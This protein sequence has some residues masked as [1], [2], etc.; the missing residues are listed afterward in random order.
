M[1]AHC[2]QLD[3]LRGFAILLVVLSHCS[4][5]KQG[6]VANAIFFALS[7]F[8]FVNPFKDGYEQRFLSAKNILKFYRGRAL[9]ILPS[10]YLVLLLI[11]LYSRFEIIPKEDF[12]KILYF[13]EPYQHLWYLYALVRILLIMP[14]VMM[15]FLLL[16]KKIKAFNNDL[17]CASVFFVLAGIIRLSFLYPVFYQRVIMKIIPNIKIYDIRLYQFILGVCAAY[18]FRYIRKNEKVTALVK[19][20]QDLGEVLI[21]VMV[22]LIIISSEDVLSKAHPYF[23]GFNIGWFYIFTVSCF[24]SV[25]V[26]LV[27]LFPDGFAGKILCSKPFQ[28]AGRLSL[29][30]YITNSFV[31]KILPIESKYFQFLCVI[32]VCIVISLVIEWITTRFTSLFKKSS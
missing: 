12:L 24:M 11:F 16:A 10:Y 31:K 13:G 17:V 2:K 9:R 32:S 8:L 27:A 1:T 22:S 21:I 19:K 23:S 7:G 18:I 20:H 30:I 6:G 3:G 26:I 29:P 5:L 25:F 4:I 15:I 28:L 14:L